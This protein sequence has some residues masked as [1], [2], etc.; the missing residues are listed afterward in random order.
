VSSPRDPDKTLAAEFP[1]RE[2]PWT[3]RVLTPVAPRW[4]PPPTAAAVLPEKVEFWTSRV[5]VRLG[6]TI[7]PP[8]PAVALLLN[9]LFLT[10]TVLAVNPAGGVALAVWQALR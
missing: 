7:P 1:V 4:R 3:V 5:P 2:D 6:V 10:T 9:V 8:F